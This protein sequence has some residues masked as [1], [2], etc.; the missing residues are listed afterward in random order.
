MLTRP[1]NDLVF[2]IYGEILHLDPA[3]I[4][5][6][7]AKACIIDT[8]LIAAIW[9][10]RRRREIAAWWRRRHERLEAGSI[11]RQSAADPARPAG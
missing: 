8:L 3:V 11:G 7:V 10:F 1:G 6:M 9:A 5:R 4:P 2:G